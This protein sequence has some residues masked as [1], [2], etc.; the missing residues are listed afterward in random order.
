M[1]NT[2]TIMHLKRAARHASRARCRWCWRQLS[3]RSKPLNGMANAETIM[4]LKR[5]ARHASRAR[6]RWCWETAVAALQTAPACSRCQ[7]D[8]STWGSAARSVVGRAA[9]GSWLLS[10]PGWC[11]QLASAS[12][13][14]PTPV[15]MGGKKPDP[16]ASLSLAQRIGLLLSQ[17]LRESSYAHAV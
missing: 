2:E 17:L 1:A 15:G 4:Q 11:L 5:A 9:Y 7:T 12:T 6:C 13:S 3:L 14:S 10:L 16:A 8:V